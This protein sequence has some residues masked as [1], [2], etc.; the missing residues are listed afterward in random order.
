MVAY[1]MV[2]SALILGCIGCLSTPLAFGKSAGDPAITQSL[3][4]DYIA[5]YGRR[6]KACHGLI[7]PPWLSW[8]SYA[9]V[10][11][12]DKWRVYAS[13]LAL[14]KMAEGT[15]DAT[16]TAAP[17]HDG[18]G[19]TMTLMLAFGLHHHSASLEVAPRP[20]GRRWTCGVLPSFWGQ[21]AWDLARLAHHSGAPLPSDF[22]VA[23]GAAAGAGYCELKAKLDSTARWSG[24]KF[25][26]WTPDTLSCEARYKLKDIPDPNHPGETI[27]PPFPAELFGDY[28]SV[29]C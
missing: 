9:S 27:N 6:A 18:A 17:F 1:S 3:P 24:G 13:S 21:Q 20:A 25:F 12:S 26:S 2:V 7:T 16:I 29:S 4:G 23:S 11:V 19:K 10:T 14:C 22:A 15:A 8:L 28:D 5:N